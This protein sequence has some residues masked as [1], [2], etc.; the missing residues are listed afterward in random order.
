MRRRAWMVLGGCLLAAVALAEPATLATTG[1][2]RGPTLLFLHGMGGTRDNWKPAVE[3]LSGYHVVLADLPGH[4]RSSLPDPFS[5]E[6]AAEQ[7]AATL[8]TLKAESTVVVGQGMGGVLALK[9]LVAHPGRARGLVLIDVSL[10]GPLKGA[11]DPDGKRQFYEQNPALAKAAFANLGRDSLQNIEIRA[12]V[13]K[14][15]SETLGLFF[16]RLMTLD[17]NQDIRAA[18]LPIL[19]VGTSRVWPL[20][21]DSVSFMQQMGYEGATTLRLARLPDAGLLVASD[22]PDTLA[23]LVDRF[24]SRVLRKGTAPQHSGTKPHGR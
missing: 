4:G 14:V 17:A 15:P 16:G 21:M 19:A 13:D 5:L 3:K 9:A 7:V 24:T 20:S 8:R 18:R 11:S 12:Q 22:Q 2:G 1:Q 6:A 23:A 10:A